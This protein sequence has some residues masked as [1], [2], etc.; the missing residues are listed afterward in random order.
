M[1]NPSA[2]P[3][4]VP[5]MGSFRRSLF[6][7]RREEVDAA[8]AA[9]ESRIAVLEREVAG[10]AGEMERM[11]AKAAIELKRRSQGRGELEEELT[12]LSNMVLEREREI[13]D[14]TGRLQE[15][16]ERHDRSIASLESVSA[17]L[18]EIQTQARGQAT[19]IRMKALREAVEVSRK[20]QEF[21]VGAEAIPEDA[22]ATLRPRTRTA[23]ATET[24]GSI[25][26]PASSRARFR[27][28]SAR[29]ATFPSWLDSRTRLD[30]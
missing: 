6:G 24:A 21:S 19:R 14:L 10:I 17:R 12:A 27:S 1:R 8:I 7:Y 30:R 23:T 16:N 18:E 20:V 28:R 4:T 29:W 3:H 2:G 22:E 5:R 11:A 9:R 13:R 25:L 26:P 15:S